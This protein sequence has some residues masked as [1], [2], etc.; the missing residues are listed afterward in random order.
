LIIFV[1][2]KI[3]TELKEEGKSRPIKAAENVGGI[4]SK[5]VL[6]VDVVYLSFYLSLALLVVT[7][8]KLNN[9]TGE[10]DLDF[11]VKCCH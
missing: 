6:N 1:T 11:K 2:A 7:L 10:G 5:D 4:K 8:K 9:V 3:K